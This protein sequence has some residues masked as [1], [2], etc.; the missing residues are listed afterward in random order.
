[1]LIVAKPRLRENTGTILE[2][3][4][5]L[6]I[7]KSSVLKAQPQSQP[8]R[9]DLRSIH[10][11]GPSIDGVKSFAIRESILKELIFWDGSLEEALTSF[12]KKGLS[13]YKLSVIFL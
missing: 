11:R 3:Q 1:M 2:N 5:G 4:T 8:K 13:R 7:D 6:F 9:T 10:R 12:Q